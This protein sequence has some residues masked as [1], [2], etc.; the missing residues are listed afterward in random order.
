MAAIM[1]LEIDDVAAVT[2]EASTADAKVSVAN[3]IV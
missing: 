2:A 1:G 3:D